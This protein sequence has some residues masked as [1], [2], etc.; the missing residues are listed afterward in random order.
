MSPVG[1]SCLPHSTSFPTLIL[2][3]SACRNRNTVLIQEMGNMTPFLVVHTAHIS[4]LKWKK[5]RLP[6][7]LLGAVIARFIEGIQLQ[8]RSQTQTSQTC[9]SQSTPCTVISI[10]KHA[11]KADIL[12][13]K[14]TGQALQSVSSWDGSGLWRDGRGGSRDPEVPWI[15]AINSSLLNKAV[16]VTDH[17]TLYL[18]LYL[19]LPLCCT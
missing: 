13:K 16:S 7:L 10:F 12:E 9:L 11:A 17:V 6:C 1:G 2:L 5:S 4:W 19:L 14:K 3:P 18:I 15:F 8:G